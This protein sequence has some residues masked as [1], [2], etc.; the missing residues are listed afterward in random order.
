MSRP[1]R[2]EYPGAFYHVTSRGNERKDIFRSPRDREKFLEYLASATVRYGARIHVYCLM[3]NHYHLLVE[4]PEGN[5]SQIMRHING[6]YTNYY[7]TKRQRS[8]HLLQGRYR[9]ILVERDEYARELSRYVHLN[10]VRAKMV[11]RPEVHPWSSYGAYVGC[12]EVPGWLVRDSVLGDFGGE[13]RDAEEGY[14]EFVASG[15]TQEIDDPL[16]QVVA[17]TLLGSAGFLAWAK[18]Q[19]L[20]GRPSV[21][22]VPALRELSDRPS[23]EAIRAASERHLAAKPQLAKRVALYLCHRMTGLRL[24]EIGV[25]FAMTDAAVSQ[26]SRRVRAEQSRSADLA[27]MIAGVKAELGMS[28]VET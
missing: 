19:F 25:A 21:R 28:D 2:I 1:L 5:L 14:R 10:P 27:A 20:K 13:G 22:E 23:I 24:R 17:S 4:T 11:E 26:A 15:L 7:N 12:A 9:A 16:G 8:G 6:A 18:E 3:S